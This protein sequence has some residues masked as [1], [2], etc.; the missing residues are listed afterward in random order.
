MRRLRRLNKK[1]AKKFVDAAMTSVQHVC[2]VFPTTGEVTNYF[3]VYVSDLGDHPL[4]DTQDERYLIKELP[5]YEQ[6]RKFIKEL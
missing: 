5:D 3:K 6:C 2:E 4:V 1:L